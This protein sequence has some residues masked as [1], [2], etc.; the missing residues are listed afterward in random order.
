MTVD[1]SRYGSNRCTSFS[2]VTEPTSVR[3]AAERITAWSFTRI[4]AEFISESN[5]EIAMLRSLG[6]LLQLFE[7]SE[8]PFQPVRRPPNC[9]GQICEQ[10]AGYPFQEK[11]CISNKTQQN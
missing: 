8:R 6:R 10:L 1:R 7:G 11:S 5:S 2:N 3:A 4:Q 9:V